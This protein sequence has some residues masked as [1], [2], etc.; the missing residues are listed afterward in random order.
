[1]GLIS[2]VYINTSEILREL[3]SGEPDKH[4]V[5]KLTYMDV[6]NLD[7]LSSADTWLRKVLMKL[8]NDVLD[9]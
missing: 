4:D 7:M 3:K 1:M 9:Y 5:V 8:K 2:I 6:S